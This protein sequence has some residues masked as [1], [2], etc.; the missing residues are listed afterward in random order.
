MDFDWTAEE[1]EIKSRVASVLDEK[2]RLELEDLEEADLDGVKR[3]T[4]A[5]MRKLADVGY[6][7][8][9]TGPGARGRAMAL[10]AAQEELA[11]VSGSLF[12][13]IET[14]ARL[15]GGVLAGFGTSDAA[16][17]ISESLAR[18]E[19]IGALA[20]S[21]PEHP[22]F[23]DGTGT[24]AVPDRGGYLL[25]GRKNYVTNA[26]IADWLAVVGD[27]GERPAVFLVGPHLPGVAI[28]PRLKTVGYNGLAVSV[29]ELN[30]VKVPE[31]HVLG[32]FDDRSPLDFLRLVQ[33][34]MLTVA[35]IGLLQRIVAA[36]RDYTH[37]HERGG[38]PVFRFQEIRFKLADMLTLCQS[39]QFLAYR[40]GWL[41]SADDTEAETVLH[42]AKVFA[43]E[44]SEQA[45]AMAMQVMAGHGYL[46]GNPVE[47]AYREAKLTG[48]A[49]TT[50]EIARMSIADD[51]LK[52]YGG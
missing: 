36:T 23:P 15:F 14:S 6:L 13:S 46:A 50:S 28:G 21:E 34:Q 25:T 32:P 9:G 37:A 1:Q 2:T 12:L 27:V 11:R 10:I 38:K 35:A 5:C 44:A 7:A 29:I 16:R 19:L 3:I 51:L 41:Y 49:G 22:P 26:L 8:L 47:R 52:E 24:G 42:C 30:Q 40:A 45:A 48:I 33:D 31:T 39:A 18:G 4:A 20:A 43:A 17:E